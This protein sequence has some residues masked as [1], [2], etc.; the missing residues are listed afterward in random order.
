MPLAHSLCANTCR[1]P[2][3]GESPGDLTWLAENR[4]D[5][6]GSPAQ[7]TEQG[8]RRKGQGGALT[9]LGRY[10]LGSW[11]AVNVALHGEYTHRAGD[12]A[13]GLEDNLFTVRLDFD[14]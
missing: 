9:A 14:F 11:Q 13:S 12:G 1:I 4:Q 8:T 3:D 7:K 10:Y 6:G 5:S 2:E